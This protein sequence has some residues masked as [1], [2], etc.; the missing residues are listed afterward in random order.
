MMYVPHHVP[1][2]TCFPHSGQPTKLTVFPQSQ[3]SIKLTCFP[4]SGQPM[5][6]E[7]YP[8]ARLVREVDLFPIDLAV[9]PVRRKTCPSGRGGCQ[10]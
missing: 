3:S 6:F 10:V 9:Y 8:T 7:L 2:L 4:Q 5:M 1:N